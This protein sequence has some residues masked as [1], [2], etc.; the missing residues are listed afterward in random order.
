MEA[1]QDL[2]RAYRISFITG[3]AVAASLLIYIFIVEF[4]RSRFAPFRGFVEFQ[5]LELI[6]YVFYALAVVHVVIMRIFLS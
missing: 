1:N 3:I 4:I 6:R 5:N 2:R